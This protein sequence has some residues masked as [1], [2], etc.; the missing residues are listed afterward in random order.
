MG[1]PIVIVGA[2]QS[3]LQVAESLRSEGW[4]GGILLLGEEAVPPYHRPP[5]SKAYLAGKAEEAQLFIRSPEALAKKHIDFRPGSR[6]AALDIA[7]QTLTLADGSKLDYEGLALATGARNRALPLPGAELAG[8]FGLRTLDDTRRIA[9]ALAATEAVVVIGGGF[10]GLE[11]AAVAAAQGKRV[12]VL[13]AAERLMARAVPPALSDFYLALHRAHGV[14]VELGVSVAAILGEQGRAYGVRCADG[15]EFEAGLVVAGIGVL[16]NDELA[17]AAGIAC[18][19]GI[20]VDACSR[21]S[22]PKVV[23]SGDCT[24]TRLEDGGLRRLESVQA[25]VEQG[26]SAAAALLGRERPFSAR[27][28]FWSDQYEVKLQMAGLAAGA[29]RSVLRGSQEAHAFSLFHY[30]GEQLLAVDSLNQPQVHMLARRM[31]D[32][33]RSPTPAQAADSGFELNTVLATPAPATSS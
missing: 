18:D 19:R 27:P 3:G 22:A 24:V 11:F 10:I 4:E 16:P 29:D 1:A 23:A 15:R 31:L 17:A 2:G 7:R 21:T 12:T 26:K 33:G 9:E 13:E 28:W 14:R 30:R 32:A 5:L 8:V 6:V 25:A 20:L